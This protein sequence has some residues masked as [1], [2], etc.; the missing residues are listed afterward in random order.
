MT[1]PPLQMALT[2]LPPVI[3]H[4]TRILILGSFP[5][6]AS[7]QAQQYYAHP[8]NQFWALL[9]AAIRTDLQGLDYPQRL[10][11]L[12]QNGI[13]LWDVIAGCQRA[14]SLDSAIRDARANPVEWLRHQCP[15]LQRVYFNGKTSGKFAPQFA[16]AG[17]A[18][19]VLPSSSPA[20]A[21]LSFAQKLVL[22]QGVTR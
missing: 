16:A 14:G 12:L 9:S 2:G 13:G 1:K 17:Y 10:A 19:G 18:T 20:N 11:C 22:W 4:A 6:A 7:L 21:Q 5:G 8:R 3:D 15:D